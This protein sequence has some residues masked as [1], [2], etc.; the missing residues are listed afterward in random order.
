[1]LQIGGGHGPEFEE[2]IPHEFDRRTA[3][4]RGESNGGGQHAFA[5]DE[6]VRRFSIFHQRDSLIYF[7]FFFILCVFI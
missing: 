3:S 7:F 1:M 5:L 4:I 6:I 2:Q